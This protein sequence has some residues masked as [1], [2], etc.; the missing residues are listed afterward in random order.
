MKF[1]M[2]DNVV[3]NGAS[4][5]NAAGVAN[6]NNIPILVKTLKSNNF[7][8]YTKTNTYKVTDK[9]DPNY[10][11]NNAKF[12]FSLDKDENGDVRAVRIQQQ[13]LKL[14][15]NDVLLDFE[16]ISKEYDLEERLDNIAYRILKVKIHS[17][18]SL[19]V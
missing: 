10:I 12:K 18:N 7:I 19:T 9:N 14:W 8:E 4:I 5:G 6:A 2:Y 15:I 3:L 11:D 16:K 1:S 13:W 17:F